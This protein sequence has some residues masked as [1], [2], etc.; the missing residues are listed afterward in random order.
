MNILNYPPG[1]SENQPERESNNTDHKIQVPALQKNGP[2]CRIVHYRLVQPEF[3]I[4]VQNL[5]DYEDGKGG[6]RERLQNPPVEFADFHDL[7]FYLAT[8]VPS[9]AFIPDPMSAGDRTT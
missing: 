9:A 3:V 4:K 5:N 8:R 2:R 6:I 1:N 7:T